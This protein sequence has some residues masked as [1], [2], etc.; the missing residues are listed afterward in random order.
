MFV[1]LFFCFFQ[2]HKKASAAFLLQNLLWSFLGKASKFF[3]WDKA[4]LTAGLPIQQEKST[5][6]TLQ[7]SAVSDFLAQ[8]KILSDEGKF[9]DFSGFKKIFI[10]LC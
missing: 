5:T 4:Q 3:S 7:I 1:F 2:C 9:C 8:D 10:S 6:M